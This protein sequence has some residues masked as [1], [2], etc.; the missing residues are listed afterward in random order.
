[1]KTITI[2]TM[3]AMLLLGAS[4]SIAGEEKSHICFHRVDTNGD[5]VITPQEFEAVYGQK[6][7]LFKTV[8]VDG[9]GRLIHDEYHDALGDGV[10]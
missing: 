7:A 10:L 4:F 1:M 5:G 9:D 6:P 3:A 2:L 8:D